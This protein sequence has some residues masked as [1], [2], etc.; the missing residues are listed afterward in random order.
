MAI[1]GVR[2]YFTHGNIL[3]HFLICSNQNLFLN[4]TILRDVHTIAT[5]YEHLIDF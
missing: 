1:P 2:I 5:H 3:L 4:M